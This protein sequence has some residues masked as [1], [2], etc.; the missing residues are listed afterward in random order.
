MK[1]AIK[2][3]CISNNIK[4]CPSPCPQRELSMDDLAAYEDSFED[5]PYAP[6]NY[7]PTVEEMEKYRVKENP[8]EYLP[9]LTWIWI[10]ATPQEANPDYAAS[11]EYIKRIMNSYYKIIDAA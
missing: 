9:F 2:T 1:E 10:R 11:M 4:K 8:A 5:F 6:H 7:Y 3:F